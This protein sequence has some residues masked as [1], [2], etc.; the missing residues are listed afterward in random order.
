MD[1]AEI[2]YL[3]ER[4]ELAILRIDEGQ[5]HMA[6]AGILADISALKVFLNQ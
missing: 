2:K 4:L 1:K 5:K 6:V 3:V